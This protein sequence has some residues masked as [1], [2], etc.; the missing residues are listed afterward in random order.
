MASKQKRPGDCKEKESNSG[1][2]KVKRCTSFSEK[3]TE[4]YSF[5]KPGP[6]DSQAFCEICATSFGCAHG[7]LNVVLFLIEL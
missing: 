2:K 1:G 4:K 5:I 6:S 3:Y 7:G